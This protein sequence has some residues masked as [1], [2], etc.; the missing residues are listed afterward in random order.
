MKKSL[1]KMML[2]AGLAFGAAASGHA[3][4]RLVYAS[5][6]GE[7]YT[8][9]KADIWVMSEIEKRSNGGIKFERYHNATLL[10]A[11]DI[12]PGLSSGAADIASGTPA[13]YNRNQYR[14]S[15]VALPYISS[16]IIAVGK[17]MKDL[18]DSNEAFQQEFER[19]GAKVLYFLPWG[20]SSFYTGARPLVRA[21]DFKGQKVRAVQAIAE[22]VEALG[23]TPVAMTWNEAVEGLTRG[24]VDIAGSIPFDSGVFGGIHE[25]AKYASDGGDQGIFSVAAISINK[26]RYDSLSPELQKVIDDVAAEAQQKYF[27]LLDESYEDVVNRLCTYK[28]GLTINVFS[29]EEAKKTADI[30]NPIVQGNWTKW[31]AS[32]NQVDTQAFLNQYVELVRKYEADSDWKSG[33]QR[34][35]DRGCVQQ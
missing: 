26:K 33:Y 23:G 32:G 12:Y 18:Y 27:E 1:G 20:E 11:P 22:S 34:L 31:A 35:K 19:R 21:E 7:A 13:A 9:S 14:L 16:D 25:S 29:D 8:V 10:K 15:N 4:E 2:G 3:A 17:A 24:V 5:Y 6:Y 28:G 30:V